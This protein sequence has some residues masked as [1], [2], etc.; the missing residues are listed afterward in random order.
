MRMIGDI[1]GD[2]TRSGTDL[3]QWFKVRE[4]VP[5]VSPITI[6]MPSAGLLFNALVQNGVFGRSRWLCSPSKIITH[7]A[8]I[9]H[10]EDLE[11]MLSRLWLLSTFVS[12]LQSEDRRCCD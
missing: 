4:S 10:C 5:S 11:K 3:I 12:Q 2:A 7:D 8:F 6:D 1:L 9:C